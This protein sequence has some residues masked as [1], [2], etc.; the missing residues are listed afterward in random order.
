MKTPIH[1]NGNCELTLK[2][3]HFSY[4]SNSYIL[5]N[6]FDFDAGIK[7]DGDFGS[8]ELREGYTKMICNALNAQRELQDL[9]LKQVLLQALLWS[10]RA[11]TDSQGELGLKLVQRDI[12]AILDFLTEEERHE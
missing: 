9:N 5:D 10:G 12:Q 11:P 2:D 3:R 6:N 4:E 7:I 8:P 1:T